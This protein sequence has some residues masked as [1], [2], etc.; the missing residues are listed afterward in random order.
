MLPF[1]SMIDGMASWVRRKSERKVDVEHRVPLPHRRVLDGPVPDDPRGVH[2]DVDPPELFDR[3][4]HEP[5]PVVL[6]RDVDA[7][8]EFPVGGYRPGGRLHVFRTP[9]GHRHF[10]APSGRHQRGGLPDA[11]RRAGD[12]DDLPFEIVHAE[13][14][15]F[16]L[17]ESIFFTRA[18]TA[19]NI[20]WVSLPVKVFCWLG[21]Y[22][23]ISTCR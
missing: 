1:R 9:G 20:E 15:G 18:K 3:R 12:E 8:D 22:D 14:T 5:G 4:R 23:A 19:S 2:Q 16:L 13:T 10:R 11:A 7:R 21:W 6:L 17:V